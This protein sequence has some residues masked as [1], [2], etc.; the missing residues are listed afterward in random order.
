MENPA[1]IESPAEM[2]ENAAMQR[3]NE[4]GPAALKFLQ[5]TAIVKDAYLS[6]VAPGDVERFVFEITFA[7]GHEG[8]LRQHPPA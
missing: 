6:G 2:T 1:E 5:R 8:L 3:A 4:D 7:L